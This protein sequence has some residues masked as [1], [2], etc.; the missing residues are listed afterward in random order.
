MNDIPKCVVLIVNMSK[1]SF[2]PPN[3]ESLFKHVQ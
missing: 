2:D 3:T 1:L